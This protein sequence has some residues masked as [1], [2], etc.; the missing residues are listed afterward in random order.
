M[1]SGKLPFIVPLADDIPARL[2]EIESQMAALYKYSDEYQALSFEASVLNKRLLE[3]RS[4][5]QA[6]FML[7]RVVDEIPPLR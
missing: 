6:V 2:V 7:G 5:E 3:V 4:A 1:S